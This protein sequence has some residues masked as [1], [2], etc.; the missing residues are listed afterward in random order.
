MY[1]DPQLHI[2]DVTVTVTAVTAPIR[3]LGRKLRLRRRY[4]AYGKQTDRRYGVTVLHGE[5]YVTAYVDGYDVLVQ[6]APDGFKVQSVKQT[7]E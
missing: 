1:K 2:T 5:Y 7:Q 6:Q 3:R 4:V